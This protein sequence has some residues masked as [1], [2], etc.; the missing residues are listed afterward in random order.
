MLVGY[1]GSVQEPKKVGDGVVLNFSVACSRYMG[2]GKDKATVWYN[3]AWWNAEKA[4]PYIEKG[5]L[6]SVEGQLSHEPRAY[7]D[8]EGNPKSSYSLTANRVEFYAGNSGNAQKE[9]T[10]DSADYSND[11]PF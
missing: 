2:A 11:I 9:E 3:V 1:V 10:V 4:F 5:K 7:L 8:K 6:V